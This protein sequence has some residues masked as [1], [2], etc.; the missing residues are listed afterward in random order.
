MEIAER[1]QKL[2][3]KNGYSQEQTAELLGISRQAV[4]KW[5][6]GQGKPDLD[7]LVRLTEI[8]NTS[9]DYILLGT[10]KNMGTSVPEKSGLSPEV[11]KML[12]S[13]AVIAGTALVTILF[14]TVLGLVA[15]YL[16]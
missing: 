7:N 9:A 4:S 6:S 14:I 15:K 5:E 16:L 3:R 11:R 10:E 1:L 8:Y 2:R 13:L 12:C